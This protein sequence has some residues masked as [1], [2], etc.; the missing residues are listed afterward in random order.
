MIPKIAQTN[1]AALLSA[2]TSAA[3]S[4][5]FG[6]TGNPALVNTLQP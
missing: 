2:F 1:L 6:I 4:V 3:I 5:G